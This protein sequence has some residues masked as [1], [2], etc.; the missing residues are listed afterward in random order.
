MIQS[1][2]DTI[3]K[4]L[5]AEPGDPFLNY[6]LALEFAKENKVAEA[7]QL[8]EEV[9]GRDEKYLGAYYQL[10]KFYEQVG[11]KAKAIEVYLKGMDVAKAQKNTKALNELR[12]ALEMVE[13]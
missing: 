1:R 10:G 4:M 8:I 3:R 11:D 13:E 6:A 9:L 5:E 7:I 12:G 2:V